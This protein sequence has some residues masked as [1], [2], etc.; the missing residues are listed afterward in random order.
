MWRGRAQFRLFQEDC[1]RH[2]NPTLSFLLEQECIQA[3]HVHSTKL[4]GTGM[5]AHDALARWVD[6]WIDE[7]GE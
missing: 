6:C 2:E 7:C 5:M 4:I 3:T 1:L